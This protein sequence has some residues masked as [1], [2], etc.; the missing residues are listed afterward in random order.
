MKSIITTVLLC[1]SIF[2]LNAQQA[3]DLDT[4]FNTGTGANGELN[5][6]TLQPDGKVLIGGYL[7][8]YN[9][10]SRKRIARINADGSLDA[11]FNPGS[12]VNGSN[13]HLSTIAL[14][15]D[16]KIL[17]GGNFNNYSGTSRNRIARL[18][19]DG[20]LDV[21]FDPGSGANVVNPGS[22]V[23][24]VRHIALQPDGKM[25]IGGSFTSYNGAARNRIARLNADGSLDASFNPGIG[26]S[27]EVYSIALQPDGKIL[28]GGPFTSYNGTSRNGIARLNADGS[29][30][31][32]FDPGSGALNSNHIACIALQPDGKILI[33]G[34]F[35]S[36]NGTSRNRIARLN[37]NGSLD[38]SFNPGIGANADAVLSIALQPDG[39][40]LIGG[41]FSS[42]QG[43]SRN[44][45]ARLNA[46]GILDV[47]FNPG[48]GATYSV[49]AIALQPNGKILI[50]GSFF[51]YNGISSNNI[52]RI[53]GNI[54]ISSP[55]VYTDSIS[56]IGQQVAWA[57]ANVSSDGGAP[58][59]SR[60]FCYNTTGNP[61]LANSTVQVGSGVG[62]YS[63]SLSGLQPNTGYYVRAFATNS[64]GTAYGN[65]L[66][67]TTAG[68]GLNS[69]NKPKIRVYPNPTTDVVQVECPMGSCIKFRDL[70]GRLLKEVTT[71][72]PVVSLNLDAYSRGSYV[73][74]I[75][76][77]GKHY[78]Q[79]VVKQ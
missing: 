43:T 78:Q 20:S 14:Q 26:A 31:A 46:D 52:A 28:I 54:S 68:L 23:A 57:Y 69:L 35:T 64:V 48:T 45:I 17:I 34:Y 41:G 79:K 1:L 47:T 13:S 39:K 9:G 18:N 5:C 29:L 62:S 19:A 66:S 74:E 53:Y 51:L 60:G 56:S 27:G 32:S 10:T 33:G 38:V 30:D 11:T 37:V 2:T 42:Y 24:I 22:G 25:L 63:V 72:S 58:V 76:N 8:S 61:T 59:V 7:S 40:I 49:E 65:E 55:I 50:G 73:L 12:G 67:F 3:G 21:T 75:D 44:R 77:Q 15:P 6:V 16:G 71:Q 4:T 70:Q 36:Y